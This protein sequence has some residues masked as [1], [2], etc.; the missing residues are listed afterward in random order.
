MICLGNTVFLIF[1]CIFMIF[2]ESILIVSVFFVYGFYHDTL[3]WDTTI[4]GMF[5]CLF[6]P[7]NKQTQV[8]FLSLI[9]G[10]QVRK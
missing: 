6:Q 1:Y 10:P 4:W 5:C 2:V 9:D 8:V 3:P 7:A